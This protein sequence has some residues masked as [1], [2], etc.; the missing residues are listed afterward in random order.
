M[1][2]K[3]K[4]HRRILMKTENNIVRYQFVASFT[5]DH[6]RHR[7]ACSNK[8]TKPTI[9]TRK[10]QKRQNKIVNGTCLINRLYYAIV[11]ESDPIFHEVLA[12]KIA[13]ATEKYCV[14]WKARLITYLNRTN[15]LY[16]FVLFSFFFNFSFFHVKKL[17]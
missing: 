12:N 1:R 4:S 3:C 7:L 13:G 5:F 11:G 9:F 15:S 16:N 14:C 8:Y 2:M 6:H 17:L 10:N